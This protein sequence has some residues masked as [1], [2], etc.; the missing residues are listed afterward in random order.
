MIEPDFL[1]LMGE[2]VTVYVKTALNAYGAR[3]FAGAGTPMLARIQFDST[4]KASAGGTETF[5]DIAPVGKIY[6]YGD[7]AVTTDDRIVLPDGQE[8][9]VTGVYRAFDE[10]ATVHHVKVTF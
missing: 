5:R 8:V 2:Q 7:V 4:V 3:S 9:V 1:Q 10:T 6:F